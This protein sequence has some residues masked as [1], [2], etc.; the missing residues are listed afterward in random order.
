M[1]QDRN[2]AELI[3][4]LAR[5]RALL[6]GSAVALRSDLDFPE[7]AKKAFQN[8]PLPWLGGAALVGIILA[9]W[10]PVRAKKTATA[11]RRSEKPILENAGKAGLLLGIL[12]MVLDFARPAATAWAQKKVTDYIAARQGEGDRRR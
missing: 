2:K 1:A 9:R 3:A 7:R 11:V 5:A 12:K 8:G 6:T 4:E 10:S